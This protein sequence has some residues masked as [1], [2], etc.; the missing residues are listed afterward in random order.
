VLAVLVFVMDYGMLFWA[1]Q[2]VPSGMAAVMLATIPTFM[3]LAEIILLRTQ[4]L[5]YRLAGALA[6]GLAGV[7]VLV[8]P[9]INLGGA[10]LYALGAFGLLLAAV[11]WSVASSLARLLPLPASKIMSAGAQMLLGGAL[12]GVLAVALGEAHELHLRAITAAGWASLA[13]LI[14]AGSIIAFTAFTWLI[15][16]VSPTRVGTYAYVNPVVAVLIG[17]FLGGEALDRRTIVGTV[18]VLASV[19]IMSTGRAV[20]A[21]RAASSDGTARVVAQA[22]GEAVPGTQDALPGARS[23]T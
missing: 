1:E 9:W 18:C 20:K 2:R 14:V 7:F 15:Q 11:S 23:Q 5:T 19:L 21:P 3:A 17:Y 22:L 10:P 6:I 8:D 4:R 13:Y 16:H 12:L